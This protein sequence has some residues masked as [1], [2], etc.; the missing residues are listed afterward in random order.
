MKCN[1]LVLFAFTATIPLLAQNPLVASNELVNPAVLDQ[2]LH[3]GDAGLI[4]WGTYFARAIHESEAPDEARKIVSTELLHQWLHSGDPGLIAWAAYFAQKTQN[5]QVLS[6]MPEMLTH[7]ASQRLFQ[8]NGTIDEYAV[9]AMLDALIQERIPVSAPAIGAVADVYPAQAAILATRLSPATSHSLLESWAGVNGNLT[10]AR[11]PLNRVGTMILA[12]HPDSELVAQTVSSSEAEI[13]VQVRTSESKWGAGRGGGIGGG[14][15]D[16]KSFLGWPPLY[17]YVL[18]ERQ[19]K[20][21]CGAS[22]L[23]IVDLDGDCILANRISEN[24]PGLAVSHV[25]PLDAI[26]RHRLIAYWLGVKP[27]DMSWQPE[28]YVTIVWTN[29]TGYEQKL[30]ELVEA[31]RQKML[32]TINA[33]GSRGLLYYHSV[34]AQPITPRVVVSVQCDMSPCP[35]G[36]A[37]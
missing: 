29:R 2:W 17:T 33:L 22:S 6:E 9:M 25:E 18:D 30:G 10:D 21:E 34:H 32:G 19:S 31:E 13:H 23:M 1:W 11:E 27:L 26:T 4:T 3:S 37:K 8:S 14:T 28:N 5:R 24:R 16:H 20:E 35:L 12:Q 36:N 7:W 15:F